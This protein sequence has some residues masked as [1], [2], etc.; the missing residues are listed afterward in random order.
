MFY[1]GGSKVVGKFSHRAS[2]I[3]RKRPRRCRQTCWLF[4]HELALFVLYDLTGGSLI[5]SPDCLFILPLGW[6]CYFWGSFLSLNSLWR[7]GIKKLGGTALLRVSKS[8]TWLIHIIMEKVWTSYFIVPKVP[9]F[10]VCSPKFLEGLLCNC[11]RCPG[12]SAPFLL[13]SS[14]HDGK[15]V[16]GLLP[17]SHTGFFGLAFFLHAIWGRE[18][19][20]EEIKEI[21]SNFFGFLL[22]TYLVT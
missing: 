3:F 2:N 20:I 11:D 8:A 22:T 10:L 15:G 14:P 17:L 6:R 16:D 19:K 9:N 18:H 1:R 13:F 4:S 12:K 7:K 21:V 5:L